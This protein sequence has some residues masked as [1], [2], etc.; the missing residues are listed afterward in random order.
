MFLCCYSF[1]LLFLSPSLRS[2]E[3]EGAGAFCTGLALRFACLRP[4]YYHELPAMR[5]IIRSHLFRALRQAQGPNRL[6]TCL[7]P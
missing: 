6:N 2:G 7:L 1:M 4:A 5:V 3:G